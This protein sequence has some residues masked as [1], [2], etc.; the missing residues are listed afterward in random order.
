MLIYSLDNI[1]VPLLQHKNKCQ[2]IT[3]FSILTL[4]TYIAWWEQTLTRD[5][6]VRLLRTDLFARS[7]NWHKKITM[8]ATQDSMKVL[9][10]NLLWHKWRRRT[11][12]NRAASCTQHSKN[13]RW[14]ISDVGFDANSQKSVCSGEVQTEV[15]V[16][17]FVKCNSDIKM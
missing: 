3:K 13:S 12:R 11:E 16:L 10:S 8:R 1:V 15:S 7:G 6:S 2:R 4:T 5:F 9:I 17:G 14:D